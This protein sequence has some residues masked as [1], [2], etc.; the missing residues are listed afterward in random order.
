MDAFEVSTLVYLPPTDVYE[1]LLDF[2]GYANY[3]SYLREVHQ[4]GDGTVDTEYHITVAWWK[5]SYTAHAKVTSVEPP[6]RID[7]RLVKD[8]RAHGYWAVEEA[9]DDAPPGRETASR[10]RLVIEF[11][12]DSAHAGMLDLPRLVSL[13]WVVNKVTPLVEREA[14]K[15]VERIVADL[16]G[17]Q[18]P[19]EL[20]VTDRSE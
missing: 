11:D 12:P 16:E 9:P 4:V 6:H 20:T 10:V 18:R 3:S 5:L 15:V 1:F 19:V 2:P 17:R 14:E 8:L 13:D 7:W